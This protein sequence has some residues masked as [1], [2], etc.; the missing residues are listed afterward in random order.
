METG[1]ELR[2]EWILEKKILPWYSRLRVVFG[3]FLVFRPLVNCIRFS[4]EENLVRG[5]DCLRY[6]LL[7][8][9]SHVFDQ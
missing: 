6:T 5:K 4:Q 8:Q 1:S 7:S 9:V 3:L 2:L